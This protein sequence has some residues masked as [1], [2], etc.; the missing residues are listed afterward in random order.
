MRPHC[1]RKGRGQVVH[2]EEQVIGVGQ[3]GGA[4]L[5]PGHRELPSAV[6]RSTLRNNRSFRSFRSS[7]SSMAMLEMRVDPCKRQDLS[8]TVRR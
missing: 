8:K 6:H 5:R 7:P 3:L 1:Q 2:F 4:Y